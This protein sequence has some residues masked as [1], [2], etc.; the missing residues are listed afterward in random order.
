MPSGQ[1]LSQM[2]G[3]GGGASCWE[4]LEESPSGI[5]RWICRWCSKRRHVVR[6]WDHDLLVR[7]IRL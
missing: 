6:V 4:A 5:C 2:T 1:I 7:W 3:S